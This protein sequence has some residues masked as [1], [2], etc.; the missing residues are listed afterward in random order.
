M[1]FANNTC[2]STNIDPARAHRWRS[3]SLAYWISIAIQC[4]ERRRERRALLELDDRM[5]ADLGITKSQAIDEA[6]KPSWT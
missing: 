4:Y 3:Y 6:R 5:L 1:S 2:S